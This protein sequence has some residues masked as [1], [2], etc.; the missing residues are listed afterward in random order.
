[1][2]KRKKVKDRL[3]KKTEERVNEKCKGTGKRIKMS[4]LVCNE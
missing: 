2:A 3:T 1:M 4:S